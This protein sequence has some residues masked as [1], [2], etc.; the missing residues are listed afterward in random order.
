[1]SADPLGDRDLTGRLEVPLHDETLGDGTR[2]VVCDEI[3]PGARVDHCAP[4]F[5]HEHSSTFDDGQLSAAER[6][7]DRDGVALPR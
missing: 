7:V 6:A 4:L 3:G 2:G 1:M 5:I